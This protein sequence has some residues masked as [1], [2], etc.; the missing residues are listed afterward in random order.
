MGLHCR[1]RRLPTIPPCYF[2]PNLQ[3][4]SGSHGCNSTQQTLTQGHSVSPAG[5]DWGRCIPVLKYLT[6]YDK[7][8]GSETAWFKMKHH[9]NDKNNI[10][11]E[12]KGKKVWLCEGCVKEDFREQRRQYVTWAKEEG[13]YRKENKTPKSPSS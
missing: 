2:P 9:E 1:C 13:H 3:P 4:L 5:G 11:Q 7:E 6:V 10:Q 8:K 12:Y